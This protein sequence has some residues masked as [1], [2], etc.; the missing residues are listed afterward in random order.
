LEERQLLTGA[1]GQ[2]A[3]ELF[4][5]SPALFVENQGQWEDESVRFVH[6]G[7]G[8]NVAM[9]DA[10]PV[11]ELFQREAA[12]EPQGDRLGR[13]GA[14]RQGFHPT[15]DAPEDIVTQTAQFS[16]RFDAANAV[17]PSGMDGAETVFNYL[18]G[19]QDAW[20]SNVPAFETVAYEGLYDGIDL[21]TR[22]QRDSLKYEFHVA[23]GA[24]YRQIQVSYEGIDGLWLDDDGELHVQTALGELVDEAPYIY[25]QLRG[26]QVEVAGDFALIDEDT[27]TF[28]I[29]GPYDASAE[30]VIDPDLAWSTYLGGSEADWSNGI[31]VDADGNALVAGRTSSPG[32][33][34]GGFDTSYDG[35]YDAFVAKLSPTGDHLWSTYLG[36]SEHDWAMG[37]A[38]DTAGN[39][40]VTGETGSAG[41]TQ[42]GF[43]TISNGT[44][45]FV[46][47]LDPDGGHLWSTYVG[48]S[49]Y[50]IG[51]SIA[52]DAAGNAMVTG[53]TASS[54]WVSGGFDT[55]YND[56]GDAFVAKLSPTGDHLW[57]TYLGGSEGDRGQGIAA[58]AAG[59]AVVGGRTESPGWVSG[60]FDTSY[61]GGF[62]VFVAKLSPTGAHI[63]STYLGGTDAEDSGHGIAVDYAGNA[64]V[65]GQTYSPGWVSDGFDTSFNGWQDAFVAKLD[66]TGG[67]LWSTYL[68]GS[69]DDMG[70]GIAVDAAGNALVAGSTWSSDWVF[71]GFDMTYN[72]GRDAFVAQLDST[73]DHLWSTYLGGS[74][75]ES[76][77]GI[78]VDVAGNA[79]V[80]GLTESPGWVSGGFDE[81][82]S[83]DR[84]AF[85]ARITPVPIT[86]T[87][88]LPMVTT[89]DG[90]I[91]TFT[92]V[93][94]TEPTANVTIGLSSDNAAEGT[95]DKTSLTFTPD[96]W[97]VPQTVTVTG[98]D[99]TLIDGDA[100]YTIDLAPAVSDDSNFSGMN[101]G[102]VWV[103]N[104]DNETVRATYANHTPVELEDARGKNP[105]VTTS[106]ITVADSGAIVD[107]NVQL[108]ISHTWDEDLRVYLIGPDGTRVT[109]F[110]GV[111]GGYDNFTGTILDDQAYTLIQDGSAPFRGSYIPQ[112]PLAAFDSTIENLA[113]DW[114]LEIQ[115]TVGKDSGTL[116][117]W[118]ITVV[119]APVVVPNSPPVAVDDTVSTPVDTPVTGNVL[120]NDN[121]GD[122]DD[123]TAAP[124]SITPTNGS[125]DLNADGSFT[126]TPNTGFVGTDSFTYVANDGTADS[127]A[128]TVT[129]VVTSEPVVS[130]IHVGDL[131][132][133]V[134]DLGRFWQALVTISVV[135]DAGNPVA[136][137]TVNGTWSGN[138]SGSESV[139][140]DP[141][142]Q[143]TVES[144]KVLDKKDSVVFTVDRIV[145]ASFDYD[146]ADNM[147]TTIIVY[148]NG[149]ALP[150]MVAMG[151]SPTM[152]SEPMKAE[153]TT[154][155][156]QDPTTVDPLFIEQHTAPEADQASDE[157]VPSFALDNA[158]ADLDLDPL[159]DGL[160]EDLALEEL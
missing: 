4:G 26:Q 53:Y 110:E 16:V 63:W 54:D 100:A 46:A 67:H 71:G 39:A 108:D 116:N 98:V 48:G 73:G 157:P 7:D 64:L 93:L 31:A 19:E 92:V 55:S 69:E 118:S 10:G 59:N 134:A 147:E 49:E 32:W 119:Y 11:F 75:Y 28:T 145:H 104:Q 86:V 131:D 8:V 79:L 70:R 136:D 6:Q 125:V 127:N 77:R 115:D 150:S 120:T 40:L 85:V 143:A 159:D 15:P 156:T 152:V 60:G 50:E 96:D 23:P 56:G 38:V 35:D 113:G 47:K 121:D 20:R 122:G 62:D 33:V 149:T 107:L 82:L 123:L 12:E 14:V 99:D 41:W 137:A 141:S 30:L 68:G 128:A 130:T 103:V 17:S 89:E 52:V 18:I 112:E 45:G 148:Q 129:I 37:I 124:G 91:A 88:T 97:D 27:Y 146:P 109:L 66:S 3:I 83:G 44:D 151:D 158:F 76:G 117:S 135:D 24:D 61:D 13:S 2:Q 142:G 43:D 36:G 105:G 114:T 102:Q 90:G 57:S 84:D 74:E 25:Q 80:A 72:G 126:Y 144:E 101:A 132:G 133:S 5:V 111:G 22:G 87:P 139:I 154:S 29:S 51:V 153:G 65:T 81:S 9:T 140:T 21:L 155:S 138:T 94:D 58:D 34:S 1:G 160:L 78:A 106:T 42:G 95:V